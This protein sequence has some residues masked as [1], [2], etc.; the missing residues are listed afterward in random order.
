[1]NPGGGPA[2]YPSTV[3]LGLLLLLGSTTA[4]GWDES[5]TGRIGTPAP[6]YAAL[7]QDGDSVAL[8]D[9]RGEVVLLNIWATWCPPCRVEMPHLQT[10][11]EKL[12]DE[13]LRIVGVSIDSQG[14][15]AAVDRF[16]SDLGVEF[17]ILRDPGDRVSNVFG[18]YGV[19]F[20]ALIDREGVVRW[21]HSGP[22]TADDPVLREVLASAL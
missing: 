19:P 14:S 1:M 2:R 9:F 8:S 6:A 13:G 18:A 16:A 12:A 7:T 11:H 22:I 4:C 17:L 5:S 15:G 20:N 3:G 21:R 10:L